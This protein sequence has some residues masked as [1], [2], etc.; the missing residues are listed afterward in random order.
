[1]LPAS[2]YLFGTIIIKLFL[3]PGKLGYRAAE[4]K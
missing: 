4:N 3:V 1:M 2:P